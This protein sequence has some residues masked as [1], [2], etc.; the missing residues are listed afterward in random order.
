MR[1]RLLVYLILDWS[2]L[3]HRMGLRLL[4]YAW[5]SLNFFDE[6]LRCVNSRG[7]IWSLID[8]LDAHAFTF[9]MFLFIFMLGSTFDVCYVLFPLMRWNDWGSCIIIISWR[10]WLCISENIFTAVLLRTHV[11]LTSVFEGCCANSICVDWAR[12]HPV[13]VALYFSYPIA[14]LYFL[15]LKGFLLGR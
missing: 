2:C 4:P 14:I 6:L 7:L 13:A 15:A 9:Q 3:G 10:F 12:F 1:R 5:H 11:T 8:L